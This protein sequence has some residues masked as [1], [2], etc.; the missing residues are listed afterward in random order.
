MQTP[1]CALLHLVV[2][3]LRSSTSPLPFAL[4]DLGFLSNIT[5]DET[6]L[7]RNYSRGENLSRIRACSRMRIYSRT[8]EVARVDSTVDHRFIFSRVF[9]RLRIHV[10]LGRHSVRSEHTLFIIMNSVLTDTLRAA[11]D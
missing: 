4:A 8:R 11:E 5:A 3:L 7:W 2:T 9:V 1:L 10:F 6:Y